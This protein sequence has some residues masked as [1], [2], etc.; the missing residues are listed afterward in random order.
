MN[1]IKL[2]LDFR[3]FPIWVYDE[4]GAFLDND[5]PEI[6]LKNKALDNKLVQL[7]DT[8]DNLFINTDKEFKYVGFKNQSE[9]NSFQKDI[10]NISNEI[11][12]IVQG[13]YEFEDAI[14]LD[15]F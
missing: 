9:K 8:Y 2:Y 4:N 6:L 13:E 15:N 1:K 5:S 12:K 7:Q 10:Q 3:A 11:Q 14:D